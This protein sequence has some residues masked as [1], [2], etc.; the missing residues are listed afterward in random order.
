MLQVE[1]LL[2]KA[3]DTNV[4]VLIVRADAKFWAYPEISGEDDARNAG[5]CECGAEVF[6]A[7]LTGSD[8][9]GKARLIG[10]GE[11]DRARDFN[12]GGIIVGHE[13][14]AKVAGRLW[15]MQVVA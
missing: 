15:E 8:G 14:Q 3:A 10:S 4:E 2:K 9:L 6:G 7:V 11:H 5:Y 13:E 1:Y 12:G